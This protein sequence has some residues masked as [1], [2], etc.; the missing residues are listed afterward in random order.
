MPTAYYILI[1]NIKHPG[2][3]LVEAESAEEAIKKAEAGHFEI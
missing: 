2:K 3:V 1:G